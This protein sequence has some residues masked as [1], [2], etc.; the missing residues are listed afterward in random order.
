[1]R[2]LLEGTG[3]EVE[4]IESE[5]RPTELSVEDGEGEGGVKAWIEMF[6]QR[7]LELVPEEERGKV[8]GE[9]RDLL[10]GVARRED[11]RWVVGYVRLR[12]VAVKK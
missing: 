4:M 3:F 9:A 5:H 12:W 10:E 11:G 1:M 7:F 8:A 6:G 2:T